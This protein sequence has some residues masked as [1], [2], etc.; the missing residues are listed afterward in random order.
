[1]SLLLD[2]ISYQTAEGLM[3]NNLNDQDLLFFQARREFLSAVYGQAWLSNSPEREWLSAN[4]SFFSTTTAFDY[5]TSGITYSLT[6]GTVYCCAPS[7]FVAITE[8][9]SVLDI[10]LTPESYASWFGVGSLETFYW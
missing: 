10:S 9:A 5:V 7:E 3:N 6:P 8:Q 2:S 1:M 4:R